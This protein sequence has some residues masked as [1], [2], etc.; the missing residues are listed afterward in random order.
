MWC[1]RLTNTRTCRPTKSASA[2]SGARLSG[3]R[4]RCVRPRAC[5]LVRSSLRTAQRTGKRGRP[6][7]LCWP[8][9]VVAQTVKWQAAGRTLGI[10]VC[11]LAGNPAQIARLLP[12]QQVLATAYIE[13]LNATFRQRLAGLCRRSRCLLRSAASVQTNTY[14]VGTVYNFCTPHQSLTTPRREPRTP[15]MAAGVSG[16]IWSVWELLAYQVAPPPYVAP[17]KRGRPP[18]KTAPSATKEA[19]TLVTV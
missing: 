6:R 3:S 12:S 1:R 14:L 16:H 15:A 17:K 7:L 13:R 2:A 18:G 8:H 10:R 9:F 19:A 11:H 4:W 5:G